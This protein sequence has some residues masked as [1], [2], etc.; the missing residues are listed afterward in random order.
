VK[1]RRRT[2]NVFNIELVEDLEQPTHRFEGY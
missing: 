2:V 1:Q